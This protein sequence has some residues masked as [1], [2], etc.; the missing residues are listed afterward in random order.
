M[1]RIPDIIIVTSV[2]VG[3]LALGTGFRTT[4]VVSMLIGLLVGWKRKW[5]IGAL[6]ELL[7]ST[8]HS[9]EGSS[10]D[11]GTSNHADCVHTSDDIGGADGHD[12]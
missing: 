2:I 8:E 4:G 1:K 7:D 11:S 6:E 10:H 3:A 5:C 12:A 9:T